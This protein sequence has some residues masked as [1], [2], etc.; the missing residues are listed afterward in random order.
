[1]LR[2]EKYQ[3]NILEVKFT[4]I[5]YTMK[6]CSTSAYIHISLNYSYVNLNIEKTE[7]DLYLEFFKWHTL[8]NQPYFVSL[9]ENKCGVDLESDDTLV[10]TSC[11]CTTAE[12]ITELV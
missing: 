2:G 7:S 3:I 12:D 5:S 1:M 6:G 8:I 11:L 4:I 9:M 10:T